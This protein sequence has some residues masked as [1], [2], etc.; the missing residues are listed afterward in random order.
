MNP[1]LRASRGLVVE[2]LSFDVGR[3]VGSAKVYN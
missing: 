1:V 3:A 2:L